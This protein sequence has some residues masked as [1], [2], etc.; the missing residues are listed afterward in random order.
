MPDR[1]HGVLWLTLGLTIS[2]L[3]GTGIGYFVTGG[4]PAAQRRQASAGLWAPMIPVTPKFADPQPALAPD[5]Q[6]GDAATAE[7]LARALAPLVASPRFGGKLGLSVVDVE[8]GEHVYGVRE[9]STVVPASTT[10]IVTATAVLAALGPY[11][12]F[13]TKVVAGESPGEVVL[14]GA[15]DP[16]LSVGEKASYEGASR[17]DAL[18]KQVKAAA[19]GPVTKVTVDSSLFTGPDRAPGWEPSIVTQGFV[20]PVNSLTI[21]GG[22]TSPVAASTKANGRTPTPDLFAGRAFAD[23]VGAPAGSVTQGAAPAGA[24]ELGSVQSPPLQHLVE[25]MLQLSDNVI[26]ESLLRQVALA[27][28]HP[29]SFEGAQNAVKEILS[30]LGL[31]PSGHGLVDGSGLSSSNKISPKLITAILH[32]TTGAEHGALRGVLAGLPVAAYSGTLANRFGGSPAAAGEVRAKTGSLARVRA[33]A[34]VVVADSGRQFAFAAITDGIP[35]GSERQAEAALD[36]IGA[37]LAGC[38]C[39]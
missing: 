19:G 17:L 1:R 12:R 35:P 34:G 8:T 5:G 39:T 26:A 11:H 32:I 4:A 15:G 3:L 33:L 30:D 24:K 38:G 9:D 23:L 16:T 2:L 29:A 22:R 31:D 20:A 21:N 7:G 27:K 14:I 18:A 36:A 37:A 6:G 28:G 25:L 13:Q 10:K